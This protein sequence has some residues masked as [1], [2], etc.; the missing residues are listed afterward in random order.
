MALLTVPRTWAS[1]T[2]SDRG[3]HLLVATRSG[4]ALAPTGAL[5]I[6]AAV[7]AIVACLLVRWTGLRMLAA[8]PLVC[9]VAIVA[10]ALGRRHAADPL[11]STIGR[12]R[13][14]TFQTD[15]PVTSSGPGVWLWVALA[16]GVVMVG[17]AVGWL[18]LERGQRGPASPRAL[19]SSGTAASAVTAR[20]PGSAGRAHRSRHRGV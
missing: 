3:A 11:R 14:G 12:L 1:A 18:V 9:G 17:A 5:V 16:C 6:V 7:L 10:L 19:R 4:W 20:S 2:L 8:L 13:I 15:E